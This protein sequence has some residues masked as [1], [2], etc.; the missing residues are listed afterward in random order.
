M[1]KPNGEMDSEEAAILFE[2]YKDHLGVNKKTGEM[3]E[4]FAAE[5]REKLGITY[6]Y[7]PSWTERHTNISCVVFFALAILFLSLC[8]VP[9]VTLCVIDTIKHGTAATMCIP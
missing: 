2:M 1:V 9:D 3:T 8:L 4:A 5:M 6:T 7:Q